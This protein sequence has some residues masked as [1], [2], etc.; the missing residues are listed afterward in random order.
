MKK[1]S[2]EVI[3]LTDNSEYRN[4]SQE[5]QKSQGKPCVKEN[6]TDEKEMQDFNSEFPEHSQN[7]RMESAVKTFEMRFDKKPM[8]K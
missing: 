5:L 3:E 4:D 1:V 2:T 8:E 7:S 6:S